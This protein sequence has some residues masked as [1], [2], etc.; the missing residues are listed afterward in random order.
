MKNQR[1]EQEDI[2]KKES[3]NIGNKNPLAILDE[4]TIIIDNHLKK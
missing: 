2:K 4:L 3:I 1:E